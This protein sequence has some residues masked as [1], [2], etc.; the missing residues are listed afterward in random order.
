MKANGFEYEV[1][2]NVIFTGEELKKLLEFSARHYD[3]VCKNAGK[4]GGFLYGFMNRFLLNTDQFEQFGEPRAS[5]VDYSREV[6]IACTFRELDTL[7]KIAE[8]ETDYATF[9]G[10]KPILGGLGL[11]FHSILQGIN[12]ESRR[13]HEAESARQDL[14][15]QAR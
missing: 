10:G 12:V 5:G 9:P 11:Q 14:M 13:I 3:G 15:N 7:A 8:Q 1:K 6:E 2:A 4:A